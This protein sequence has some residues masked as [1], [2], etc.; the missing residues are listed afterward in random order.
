M[1]LRNLIGK[2]V[3][4]TKPIM[5]KEIVTSRIPFIGEESKVVEVPDYTFCDCHETIIEVLD[6]VQDTPIVKVRVRQGGAGQK[7]DDGYV[8][9]ICAEYDDDNWKDI[10]S[11]VNRV[12]A[13][14]AVIKKQVMD[15]IQSHMKRILGCD[16]PFGKKFGSEDDNKNFEDK[17]KMA[18]AK[19]PVSNP[20]K[21]D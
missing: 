3:I 17:S 12:D 13:E 14:N 15:D 20:F 11:V 6:V 9:A 19:P 8:R 5:E 16:L 10:T 7:F 2:K 21:E 4:R 1:N 18:M